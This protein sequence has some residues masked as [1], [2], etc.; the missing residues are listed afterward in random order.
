MGTRGIAH[1]QKELGVRV[2]LQCGP[3]EPFRFKRTAEDDAF[4]ELPI[5][6]PLETRHVIQAAEPE[7]RFRIARFG[8]FQQ[9]FQ[10]VGPEGFLREMFADEP[11]FFFVG[12]V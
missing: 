6:I 3:A 2:P 8:L 12:D 9:F 11:A 1:G 4:P 5:L 7:L 10:F